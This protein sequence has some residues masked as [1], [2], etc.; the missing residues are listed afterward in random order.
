MRRTAPLILGAGPAGCAAAIALAREGAAPILLDRDA[1]VRDCLCGGFLS[2]RTVDQLRALGVNPEVL[3]AR[4]VDRLALLAHGAEAV[5]PLPSPAWSLSRRALDS[6][7]RQRA[8]AL[9]ATLAVDTARGLDGTTVLG[10]R[11]R[12]S[13]D[14]LF[15]ATGK[16]DLRGH[17]RPRQTNDPALGLRLRLPS[18]PAREALLSGRIELH[19]FRGGYAGMVLQEDGSANLCLALRK[20]VLAACGGHPVQL[21]K[22]LT[23]RSPALSERLGVEWRDHPIESIGAVPYGLIAEQTEPGLFHLGDQAA[24]IPSL[25]GEGISIALASGEMAAR[26]WLAGGSATA[27]AYQRALARKA[28]GP[29]RAAGLAR[30]FA[31]SPLGARAGVAMAQRVPPVLHWLMDASRIHPDAPLA[32][33]PAAP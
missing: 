2:W 25:A 23:A 22:Q 17:P 21:F 30:A 7:L 11:Q 33:A 24:V 18:T 6:A 10:Q 15:L 12:W 20:S 14:G 27:P 1:D 32:Q 29:M 5:V 28:R 13:G 26:H 4:R 3:G 16:H 19:L 31:E 8:Q 9:G